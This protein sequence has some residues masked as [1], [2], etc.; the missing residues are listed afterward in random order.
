MRMIEKKSGTNARKQETEQKDGEKRLEA[1][2]TY[3]HLWGLVRGCNWL[4]GLI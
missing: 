3:F 2:G 4:S 1:K